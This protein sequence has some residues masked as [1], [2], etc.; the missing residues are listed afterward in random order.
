VC[1][2]FFVADLDITDITE[3]AGRGRKAMLA[4]VAN[5]PDDVFGFDPTEE[6]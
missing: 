3:R 6:E 2:N 1:D 5:V 4:A